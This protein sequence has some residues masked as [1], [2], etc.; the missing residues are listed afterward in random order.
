[1]SS[2]I[3]RF[4]LNGSAT[5]ETQTVETGAGAG[6]HA[7]NPSLLDRLKLQFNGDEELAAKLQAGHSETLGVLFERHHALLF[8]NARRILRNHAEAEDAVQQIFPDLF[9]SVDKFDPARGVFKGWLVM[10]RYCRIISRWRQLQS[11]R[12]YD[13]ENFEDAL[14]EIMQASQRSFPFQAAEARRLVEQALGMIKPRQRRTIELIYYE[15]LTP[16]VLWARAANETTL[17]SPNLTHGLFGYFLLEGLSGKADSNGDGVITAEELYQYVSRNV[18]RACTE[19]S[20]PQH[21]TFITTQ[22]GPIPVV[23]LPRRK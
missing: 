8:H 4:L 15:G 10:F 9:R 13:S 22:V 3:T 11:S 2:R 18:T 7:G 14:P 19:L 12:L 21:P 20:F 17:D 1:M 6:D 16:A 23:E 5:E